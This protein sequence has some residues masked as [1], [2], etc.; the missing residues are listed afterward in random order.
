MITLQSHHEAPRV[1][2]LPA[3]PRA[4]RHH[5]ASGFA[6]FSTGAAGNAHVIAHRMLEQGRNDLGHKLLGAWL[7]AHNGT[8]SDWIHLHWHMAVFDL[9]LGQWEAALSRLHKHI[10][11]AAATTED[12]LTD[13]PA[14]LW[15]LTLA[16]PA[17]VALPWEPVRATALAR[18][19]RPSTPYV[20]LHNL[21]ALAGARDVESLD[22][23]LRSTKP[24]AR[25]RSR[26]LLGRMAIALRAYV[27][28]DY[29]RAARV[30][31]TVVPSIGE[32]GGSREQNQLFKD[33]EAASR[34]Q[35]SGWAPIPSFRK[36]A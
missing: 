13:A 16:S 9:A 7:D 17:P 29:G 15:R 20:E 19:R 14:L 25:S 1:L 18:M 32:I 30:L 27:T 3:S 24:A 33:L 5:D 28:H 23:W 22:Q 6:L 11:P 2:T 34:A 10:L 21:L 26:A 8:G 36:A 35:A 31:A 4:D 12:A